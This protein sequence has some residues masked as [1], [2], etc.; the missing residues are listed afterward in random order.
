MALLT[1]SEAKAI[2]EKVLGYSKADGFE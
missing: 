2:L 1:K